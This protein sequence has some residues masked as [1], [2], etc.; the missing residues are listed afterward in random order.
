MTRLFIAGPVAAFSAAILLTACGRPTTSG[1]S[2]GARKSIPEAILQTNEIVPWSQAKTMPLASMR[3]IKLQGECHLDLINGQHPGPVAVTSANP[4]TLL[5]FGGWL[6]AS[7]KRVPSSV[8]LLL[9]S[10]DN[11][12][13]FKVETGD[14]RPDVATALH[15]PGADKAGFHVT[16]RLRGVAAGTYRVMALM[17]LRGRNEGCDMHRSVKV[18][19][20]P[21]A[22]QLPRG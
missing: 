14:A 5:R 20:S 17:K 2:G 22:A 15:A 9:V 6:V 3:K 1:S 4:G 19:G 8:P 13:G 12:Y 16:I 11:V 18:Q 7:N 21:R 10:P